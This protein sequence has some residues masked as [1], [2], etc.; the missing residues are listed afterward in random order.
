MPVGSE[1]DAVDA[2][3]G[4]G[5][6]QGSAARGRGRDIPQQRLPVAAAGRERLAGGDGERDTTGA[7]A[8]GGGAGEGRA[9]R[10]RGCVIPQ[11]CLP[12]VTARAAGVLPGERDAVDRDAVDAVAGGGLRRVAPR[13]GAAARSHSSVF[14]LAQPAAERLTGAA[15]RDALDDL[16]GGV[17]QGHAPPSARPRHPTAGSSRCR[18]PA[19]PANATTATRSPAGA[20]GGDNGKMLRGMTRPRRRGA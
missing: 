14:P 19:L 11:Q 15:E 16:A 4:G 12:V 20:R 7:L 17:R 10:E 6:R 9:A 8:G 1:R 13:A 18:R 5:A 2:G 3:A